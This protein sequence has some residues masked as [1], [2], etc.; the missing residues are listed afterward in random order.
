[1]RKILFILLLLSSFSAF[2]QKLPLMGIK[3]RIPQQDKV[4][5]A[6]VNEVAEPKKPK[7]NLTY[8]WYS[9]N[10]IQATQGGFSG[11]LL[12]G[13]YTELYLNKGLKEQGNFNKGLK[14]G[15]WKQWDEDG[16]LKQV[17][18]WKNGVIIPPANGPFYKR[19]HLFKWKLYKHQQ[20]TANKK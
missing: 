4:I 18:E 6:E 12:D 11:K 15:S 19:L 13:A 10:T 16:K 17:T 7:Q 5:I 8:Y 14:T 3:V 2:G 1:M 20:D 9:A